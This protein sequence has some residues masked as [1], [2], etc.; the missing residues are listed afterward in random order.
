MLNQIRINTRWLANAKGQ[1][2]F[3]S[4][5]ACPRP[6]RTRLDPIRTK[7]MCFSTIPAYSSL[8][9]PL[10]SLR[11]GLAGACS[12]TMIFSLMSSVMVMA[13]QVAGATILN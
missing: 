6:V 8:C 5:E 4:K 7:L 9:L 2:S 3:K 12:L 10:S 1:L 11:A 13:G